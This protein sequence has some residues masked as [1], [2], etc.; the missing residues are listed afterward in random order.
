MICGTVCIILLIGHYWIHCLRPPDL[1]PSKVNSVITHPYRS[2]KNFWPHY[3][4]GKFH[5]TKACLFSLLS[6]FRGRPSKEALVDQYENISHVADRLWLTHRIWSRRIHPVA[7]IHSPNRKNPR[8]GCIIMHDRS[9]L[10][11]P[12]VCQAAS[13]GIFSISTVMSGSGMSWP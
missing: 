10:P 9:R 11:S 1:Q 6:A 4:I 7:E 3:Y 8:M 5:H 12:T 2:F 13:H